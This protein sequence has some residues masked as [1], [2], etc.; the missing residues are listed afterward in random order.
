MSPKL[1]VMIVQISF[2]TAEATLRF[3][4]I[5]S[6]AWIVFLHSKPVHAQLRI[7]KSQWN[8]LDAAME[9]AQQ[10]LNLPSLSVA[11]VHNGELVWSTSHGVLDA[12]SS[13]PAN[14][15]T[16]Y[17]VASNTKAFTS[18]ALAQLVDAGKL[19]WNDRVQTH[20][21]D[22]ELYDSYVTDELRIAD[23]LCHRSGLET[24]SGD[25]LWYGTTWSAD[26]VLHKARHLE[27]TSG[28]RTAFGY[29]N[30]LY[31]AAG[32]VI[33]QVTGK[34]WT[35]VVRD[36]LL[37]PLGMERAVLSTN[38]LPTLENVALPHNEIEDGSL[39][40]IDWV[41][42]D[43]MAPAGALI[44]SVDEMAHWMIAQ[45]DS[46]RVEDKQLWSPA[47]TRTMWSMHTPI[48]VSPFY[49]KYLPSMHFRGYGLGW[50]L[51]TLH[52]RKVVGHS[53]GYDGMISR[54]L[55][56]PDEKLGIFIATNTN[57]SV[58]W[59]A[60]FDAL[61][62]LLESQK[63]TPMLDF[64]REQRAAEPA[65]K[66]AE[67]EALVASRIPNTSPSLPLTSYVGTYT[68]VMYGDLSVALN[69][70]QLTFDFKPTPLFY[71]E[72]EHWHFDT[73]R[74]HWGSQM[75][76]PSGTAHFSLNPSGTI[77]SL[78]IDVPNPDFDFTEL[79][80]IKSE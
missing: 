49:N 29:Q 58:P 47:Q 50:E 16:M 9:E 56:V 17:A 60:G 65:E 43:N 12:T 20:L 67:E 80:F 46:G 72:L 38:E 21:P 69:E 37:T 30:I 75:M 33:E 63:T 71:G 6:F 24:F 2:K 35:E 13:S 15:Q 14:A 68:D 59:A 66:A 70:G 52:G 34:P 32:K 48:P 40:P 4:G 26:E 39:T 54:Q 62:I 76:L 36:S 8:R 53:G 64:L 77:E 5:L 11:V 19:D 41:N 74:L 55:L 61:G 27:P 7:T 73:F 25:L 22:F 28:F 3:I 18:A 1:A 51:S 31:I 42:W 10:S 78:D 45:M 23:L 79:K 44:T 57:S